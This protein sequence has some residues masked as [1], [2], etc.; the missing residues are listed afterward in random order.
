MAEWSNLLFA[1]TKNN[2]KGIIREYGYK[3]SANVLKTE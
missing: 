2:K 1:N 3:Y